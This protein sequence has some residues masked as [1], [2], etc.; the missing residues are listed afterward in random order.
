MAFPSDDLAAKRHY[1]DPSLV[2]VGQVL[3]IPGQ[4]VAPRQRMAVWRNGRNPI[5]RQPA[6]Q[7]THQP[8]T[9]PTHHSK[10]HPLNA[11][12][13]QAAQRAGQRPRIYGSRACS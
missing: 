4:L 2:Y 10:R 7:P 13:V 6:N 3:I 5:T 9:Q 8:T 11:I 1:R 12:V